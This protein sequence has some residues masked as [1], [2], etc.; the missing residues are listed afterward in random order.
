MRRLSMLIGFA[1][2]SCPYLKV[3]MFL[4]Y[5]LILNFV[6][7]THLK[8]SFCY[9]QIFSQKY[10]FS[11]HSYFQPVV[12]AKFRINIQE[13]FLKSIWYVVDLYEFFSNDY[14]RSPTFRF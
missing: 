9:I 11:F 12:N 6:I 8:T 10:Q 1:E 14:F 5:I 3:N 4:T 7:F 13:M 2:R